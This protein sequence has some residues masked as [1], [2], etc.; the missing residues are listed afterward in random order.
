MKRHILLISAAIFLMGGLTA[1]TST[2]K[3]ECWKS[4]S[5]KV[6][7]DCN[8]GNSGVSISNPGIKGKP[9]KRSTTKDEVVSANPE[10]PDTPTPS[11]N[12]GGT[13]QNNPDQDN[14]PTNNSNTPEN[15]PDQEN[16]NQNDNASPPNQSNSNDIE[17]YDP[18]GG[19]YGPGT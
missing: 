10:N 17:G 13:N 4:K 7:K 9:S 2:P 18:F 5:T 11:T 1:C 16:S 3:Q 6:S 15:I 8:S 19:L 14:S 12:Q